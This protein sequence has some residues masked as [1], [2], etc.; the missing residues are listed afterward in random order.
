MW[1]CKKKDFTFFERVFRNTEV[2]PR[3]LF[4]FFMSHCIKLFCLH[5]ASGCMN[6][7]NAQFQTCFKCSKW[8]IGC[9]GMTRSMKTWG[10]LIYQQENKSWTKIPRE[11]ISFKW[12]TWIYQLQQEVETFQAAKRL[13]T[14]PNLDYRLFKKCIKQITCFELFWS[15][16]KIRNKC[17]YEIAHQR[18]HT[19][20]FS[21]SVRNVLN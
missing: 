6:G 5:L 8:N 3:C 13:Q 19:N 7:T 15:K 1:N 11:I 17:M 16:L 12:L 21:I 9:M 18:P 20:M 4:W 2:N 14:A 10:L